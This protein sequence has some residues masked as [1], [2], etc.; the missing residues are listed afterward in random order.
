MHEDIHIGKLI[1]Q[2]L[3]EKERSV[4]WLAQ[5]VNCDSSNFRKIL[6]NNHIHS[7]LLFSIS[8][9]LDEDFFAFYS[10]KLKEIKIG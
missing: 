1:R 8:N 2:K 6:K 7:E 9:V 3:K 5:K 10:Q 4:A